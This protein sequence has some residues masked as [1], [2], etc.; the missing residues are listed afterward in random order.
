MIMMMMMMAMVEMMLTRRASKKMRSEFVGLFSFFFFSFWCF[1]PKGEKITGFND[2]SMPWRGC[3]SRSF[4]FYP[5][6]VVFV[7]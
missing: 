4:M 3:C 7:R 5:I 1:M 2:F 6:R